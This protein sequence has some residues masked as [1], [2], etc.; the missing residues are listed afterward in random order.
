M[1][2]VL[3]INYELKLLNTIRYYFIFYILLL[4]LILRSLYIEDYI[5]IKL[6]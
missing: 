3:L 5:I 4:K 6:N 1:K 2:K